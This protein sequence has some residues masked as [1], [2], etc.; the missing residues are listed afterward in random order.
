MNTVN[1][2]YRLFQARAEK[3]AP[4]LPTPPRFEPHLPPT[5]DSP[6]LTALDARFGDDA[7][8]IAGMAFG[9]VYVDAS[10]E[11]SERRITC[12]GIETKNGLVYINAYCHERRAP[13]QFRVDRLI[14]ATD[15]RTGEIFEGA[16]RFLEMLAAC[17]A[18]DAGQ[19]VATVASAEGADQRRAMNRCRDGIRILTFLAR[20]DGHFHPTERA[21]IGRYCDAR[22]RGYDDLEPLRYDLNKMLAYA[23]RQY[24]DSEVFFACLDRVVGAAE[25]GRHVRLIAESAAALIDADGT[26][27]EAEFEFANELREACAQFLRDEC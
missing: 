11:R 3:V 25:S 19:A 23:D 12:H 14:S 17:G 10:G 6:D 15:W 21:V 7:A 1:L 13:R 27:S 26:I 22:C 9:I 16:E 5:E 2:I 24:P 8:G 20:C 18:V 4:P